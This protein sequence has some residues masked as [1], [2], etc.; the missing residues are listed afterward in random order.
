M[1]TLLSSRN[2]K[3]VTANS[4][5]STSRSTTT[6]STSKILTP[7]RPTA[8]SNQKFLIHVTAEGVAVEA[9]VPSLVENQIAQPKYDRE[10]SAPKLP[11]S[12]ISRPLNTIIRL[13]ISGLWLTTHLNRS[14]VKICGGIGDISSSHN[15]IA[16]LQVSRP[17]CKPAMSRSMLEKYPRNLPAW[18]AGGHPLLGFDV[19]WLKGQ[20]R[21]DGTQIRSGRFCGRARVAG[22]RCPLV[23]YSGFK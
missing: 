7:K 14:N 19:S 1:Q 15:G 13:D 20:V 17:F 5:L 21:S 2:G 23:F 3:T 22:E 12:L 8:K 16:V 9:H 18:S 10:K 6:K 11:A 4:D